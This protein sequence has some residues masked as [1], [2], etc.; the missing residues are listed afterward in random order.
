MPSF[1]AQ[2]ANNL[3]LSHP[4]LLVLLFAINAVG[5]AGVPFPLVMQIVLVFAG[6]RIT[7]GNPLSVVP[8]LCIAVL[9]S[10]SGANAIYWMSR[11][12]GGRLVT[13]PKRWGIFKQHWLERAQ[14]VAEKQGIMGITMARLI[15]GLHPPLSV[16]SG[17]LKVPWARFTAAVGLSEIIWIAPM[18]TIG[19]V[20]GHTARSLDWTTNTYPKAVALIVAV[21]VLYFALRFIWRRLRPRLS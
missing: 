11:Y 15:P 7:Q 18:V 17:A 16:A 12:A 1:A 9:G 10:L 2:F 13:G 5:E 6:Y 20:A 14:A 21:M 4:A 8:L 19:V 3:N